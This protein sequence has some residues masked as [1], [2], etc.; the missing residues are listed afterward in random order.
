MDV[1]SGGMGQTSDI[2]QLIEAVSLTG[3]A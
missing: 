2:A 1:V 3:M